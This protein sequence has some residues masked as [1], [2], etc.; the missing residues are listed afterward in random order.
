MIKI[1]RFLTLGFLLTV[2]SSQAQWAQLGQDID[3]EALGDFSGFSVSISSDGSVVAIG[4]RGN[5]GTGTNAGHVRVYENISGTW[6]QIGNDIDGEYAGDYSG[7]SVS[8]SGDGSTVA[9]GARSND[10]EAYNAGHVRIYQNNS[11][12]WTQIGNDIDGE[13]SG[14]ESGCA[15]SLSDDGTIVAIGAYSNDG[16]G[17]DAGHVR[18]FENNSGTWTQIGNDIDA[19][20]AYDFFGNAVSLSADGSIVAIG[21]TNNDGFAADAGHVR[22]FENISGTWTQLGSDIDGEAVGDNSGASVS[23]SDDGSILAVGAYGNDDNGIDAGQAKVYQYQ[24]GTW[25]QMGN[26]INGEAADDY[27][28]H[29]LSLNAD[30]SVLAVGA[31]WNDGSGSNAGHVRVFQY[32]GGGWIQAGNDIDGENAQ[33][34]SGLSVS[35]SANGSIVA[36]GAHKNQALGIN[37]GHVRMYEYSGL[38]FADMEESPLFLYPNPTDDIL[39]CKTSK[40][41]IKSVIITDIS[42][43]VVCE[44]TFTQRD[45]AQYQIE[46]SMLDK[47]MYFLQ[48]NFDAEIITR[49][50]LKL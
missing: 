15:V 29:S 28:G 50:I 45:V 20:A 23:L 25:T 41:S 44:K 9:I 30:G 33:D 4:A 31:Y 5:D 32:I 21:A 17:N 42:G 14:D 47:G 6:M 11:G 48:I 16:N 7:F 35:I 43:K 27:F 36:I 26:D 34:E 37:T 49:K 2:L 19:E 13:A 22:V 8:I 18:I 1:A 12:T 40:K 24:G 38:G 46:L 3:G 39:Y 10:D